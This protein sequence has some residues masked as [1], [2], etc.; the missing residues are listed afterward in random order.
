[1]KNWI[2]V[3]ALLIAPAVVI[4]QKVTIDS[5]PAGQFA[6]YKTYGWT[7]GTPASNPLAESRIHAAVEQQLAAKGFTKSNN[8]DV[9]VA[10]LVATKE[11]KQLIADGFGGGFMWGGGYATATVQTYV[12]GTLVVD[13]Y[14]AHKKQLVWRATGTDTLSSKPEKNTHKVEKALAK[15][16]EKYPPGQE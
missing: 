13:V 15:M 7:A 11:Q 9:M 10:T 3:G 8:P 12:Q 4:A 2:A 6:S 1:M 5:D 14:D 16:F